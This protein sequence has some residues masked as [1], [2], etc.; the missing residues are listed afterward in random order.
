M[1]LSVLSD[2]LAYLKYFVL[3]LVQG[4]SEILPISSSGHLVFY[5]HVLDVSFGTNLTF[6]V[7]LH[8]ASLLALLL[9]FRHLIIDL[10]V[11]F[12]RFVFKKEK[13]Y[14]SQF[15]LAIYIVVATIP[16][17]IVGLL[18][19]PVIAS[20]FS[21]LLF[22]AIGFF[23][24]ASILFYVYK[25]TYTEE[26]PL[27]YKSALFIGLAQCIGVFPGVSRSGTT[28]SAARLQKLNMQ[29]AKEFVFLLFI[30]V[31][32]GSFIM[33]IGDVSL[34]V[35]QQF[36]LNIVAMISSFLFTY[37]ALVFIFKKLQ[38]HHYK[39]FS[40]YCALMAVITFVIALSV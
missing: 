17:V 11:G 33:S 9:F 31:S 19:E 16:V 38:Y 28:L 6:E 21:S 23:I 8:F 2:L 1:V 13:E 10:I 32:L 18:L 14:Q 40:I 22:V 34:V 4:I 29:K 35:N 25:Q 39:Y 37:G 5:Q 3:G 12:F 7:L 15:M 24:T 30:P 20:A 26:K 27:N 36:G